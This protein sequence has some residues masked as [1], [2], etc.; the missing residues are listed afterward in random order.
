M[1]AIMQFILNLF[2]WLQYSIQTLFMTLIT[3]KL[4]KV[5]AYH[6]W[7]LE[8][9]VPNTW[10]DYFDKNWQSDNTDISNKKRER[11]EKEFLN[12]IRASK[13]YKESFNNMNIPILNNIGEKIGTESIISVL[14]K[15]LSENYK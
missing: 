5:S 2:I 10:K 3:G 8:N 12:R 1:I 15:C 7:N 6:C 4:V 9:H 11:I 13:T 14:E